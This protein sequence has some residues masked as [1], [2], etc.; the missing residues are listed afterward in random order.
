M[1]PATKKK[2]SLLAIL[3]VVG[4]FAYY[5]RGHIDDFRQISLADP[6]QIILLV[7]TT[8][9]TAILNGLIIKYLAEPFNR[10]LGAK[11]WFGLATVT[12]FYNMIMPLKSGLFVKAAYLK[13]K[14]SFSLVDFMAMMAGVTVINFFIVGI[15][16]L[17]SLLV[18]YFRHG[19]FNGL[20]TSLFLGLLAATSAIIV[21]SRR[22]PETERAYLNRL[23]RVING[24]HLIKSNARILAVSSTIA[25]LQ[26]VVSAFATIVSFRI[27]HLDVDVAGALFITA[28]GA[29]SVLVGIT[30]AS[31]GI[32]EGFAIMTGWVLG[33][34]T[35]QS[36]AAA[37]L[38]RI[39]STL[40]IFV[41]GPVFSYLLLKNEPGG[42]RAGQR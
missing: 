3:A 36:L 32:T 41:L 28:T 33:I 31:L 11:E 42:T 30:P 39:V 1:K 37:L 40:V 27:I 25:L 6:A 8:L 12:T 21:S 2:V 16:G 4:F 29:L 26:I 10:E 14:H 9:G 7:L 24:W 5:I 23:I 19:I 20:V 13:K 34:T 17:F 35:A 22:I 18:M 15:V 38:R